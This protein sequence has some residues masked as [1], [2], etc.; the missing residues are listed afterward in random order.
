M[1]SLDPI[2]LISLAGGLTVLFFGRKLFWV[3]IG[4]LGV[5]GG[6]ELT[7][8]LLPG[9]S[10]IVYLVVAVILGVAM[11]LLA[12]ALQYVAVALAGFVGGAY[13]AMLIIELLPVLQPGQLQ[14]WILVIAGTAGALVCLFMFNP[15][16]I[17]LSSLTGAAIL[18]QLAPMDALLQNAVLVLAA[19]IGMGFQFVVYQRQRRGE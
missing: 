15:A 18:A 5:L 9:Q 12:M 6:F 14:V 11:A 16:L 3:Y 19:A 2:F 4:L 10:E 1:E 8:E 17:V 13:L 7:R